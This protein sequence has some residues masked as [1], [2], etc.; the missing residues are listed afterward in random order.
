MSFPL[1]DLDTEQLLIAVNALAISFSKG[2]TAAEID[3]LSIFI[4]SL[5]DLL[6]LIAINQAVQEESLEPSKS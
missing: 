5:G 3:L 2:L 6:A 4:T 1:N